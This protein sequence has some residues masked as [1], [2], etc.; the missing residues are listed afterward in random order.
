MSL[1]LVDLV[2]RHSP[3]VLVGLSVEHEFSLL[4]VFQQF[5]IAVCG[6]QQ[7]LEALILLGEFDVTLLVGDDIGVGNQGPD[8]LKPGIQAVQAL[9]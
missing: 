1:V 3:Q 4:N 7:G 6:R 9:Q 8:F 5:A 2:T